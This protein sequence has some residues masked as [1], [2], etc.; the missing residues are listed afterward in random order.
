MNNSVNIVF[1]DNKSANA[2]HNILQ[3]HQSFI[4]Q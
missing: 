4:S 3:W 2:V 1:A